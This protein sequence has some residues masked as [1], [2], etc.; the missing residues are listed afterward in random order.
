MVR[1]GVCRVICEV[2]RKKKSVI[3]QTPSHSCGGFR[4]SIKFLKYTHVF[5]KIF[6]ILKYTRVNFNPHC[7][8]VFLNIYLSPFNISV[9]MH[10]PI[11][12]ILI[13]FVVFC[14]L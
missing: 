5:L 8:A 11:H 13:Q 7:F 10:V 2:T 12:V 14:V 9:E 4:V 3:A 1:Q 6:L